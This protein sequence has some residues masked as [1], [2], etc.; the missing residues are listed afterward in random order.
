MLVFQEFE[1]ITEGYTLEAKQPHEPMEEDDGEQVLEEVSQQ[2]MQLVAKLHQKLLLS[3]TQTTWWAGDKVK[4][5]DMDV[6]KVQWVEPAMDLYT[7]AASII[8]NSEGFGSRLDSSID[9]SSVGSELLTSAVLQNS[10][11]SNPNGPKLEPHT[12]QPYDFYHHPNVPEAVRCKGVLQPLEDRVSELL[13]E[14]PEHPM[15]T[16]VQTVIRRILSFPV[17]S[18]LSKLVTGLE[19]LLQKTQASGL[20]QSFLI[21]LCFIAGSETKGMHTVN[22]FM[23]RRW[24]FSYR[25]LIK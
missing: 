25:E 5:K 23:I 9:S 17:T 13:V 10:V 8:Q 1:D 7:I 3:L 21:G 12:S 14:W 11:V 18:P 19:V 20:K 4:D 24:T 22:S 15:L 2:Q 16:A 6:L